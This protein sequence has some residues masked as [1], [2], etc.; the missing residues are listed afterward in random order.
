MDKMAG[1]PQAVRRDK[2]VF[3]IDQCMKGMKKETAELAQS[4]EGNPVQYATPKCGEMCND[5]GV[6]N[7]YIK[8]HH[9]RASSE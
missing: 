5:N 3:C 7:H 9:C 2:K 6:K 1:R 8:L 4:K